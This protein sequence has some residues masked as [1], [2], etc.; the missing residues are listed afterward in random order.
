MSHEIHINEQGKASFGF[1]GDKS[2]IWHSL[3]QELT[4]DAPIEVWKTEAGFDWEIEHTPV[5]YNVGDTPTVFPGKRVLYR[6]DSKD[7]LSIVS[8]DYRIVQPTEVLEFFRDLVG[9]AGMQL[10]TAG[11]LF[12]GRRFWALAETKNFGKVN[13]NDEVKGNLLL[14]SSCDGTLATTASFVATRV[15][16]NNTLRIALQEKRKG[17]RVSHSRVFD[18][19]EIKDSLGL[20]DQ[21]WESFMGN[22]TKLSEYDI[23]EEKAREFVYSLV[24]RPDRLPEDQPYTVPQTINS[25]IERFKVGKGNQGKTLWDLL[26]GVTEYYQYDMGR[27][28]T[29]DVKLW[30]NFYGKDA[31]KKDDAYAKALELIS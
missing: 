19:R 20:I 9:A 28:K 30:D 31:D 8:N 24:A 15:V 17:V 6:S 22:I 5:I 3:G 12:G 2:E 1:I 7:S 27:T 18:P 10:S 16:C 26:N 4:K 11:V 23:S 29:S 21:A 25:I 14:S 13:G